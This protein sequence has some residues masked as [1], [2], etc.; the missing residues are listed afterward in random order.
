MT[1][2]ELKEKG[3]IVVP[4]EYKKYEKKGFTTPTGKVELYS[5]L[6]EKHGHDPLPIYREP[7]LS[8]VSTPELMKDYPL[9]LI[10]GGRYINFFHSEGRQISQLRKLV[11]DPEIEIHPDTAK[12]M[13]IA[14]GDW[15]W[16]EAPKVEGERVRLKAKLTDGID[17]KVVHAAHAWWFPEKPAPEHGC[18]DSNINVILS[19]AGP[20]EEVCGSVASRG[21]LCRV[22]K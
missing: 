13:G 15:V 18:F 1:F 6:F 2:D 14:D 16:V 17:P 8:P 20:R 10:T 5:T 11:P 3:Y 21:T 4:R 12:S 9:I 7:L 19:D 22:Y